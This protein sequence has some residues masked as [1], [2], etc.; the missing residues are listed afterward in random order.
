MVHFA[1]KVDFAVL[2]L[3]YSSCNGFSSNAVFLHR[4]KGG[5]P[6]SFF[7]GNFIT[8]LTLAAAAT[9]THQAPALTL[10]SALQ[11]PRPSPPLCSTY[12]YCFAA[13]DQKL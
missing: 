6:L 11:W 5:V 3:N 12:H 10:T 4:V 1:Q 9:A 13:F 2:V 7:A 8:S